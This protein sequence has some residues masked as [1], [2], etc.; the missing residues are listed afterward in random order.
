MNF[1]KSSC[2]FFITYRLLPIR[3]YGIGKSENHEG[4]CRDFAFKNSV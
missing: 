2:R 4:G 3:T 1:K